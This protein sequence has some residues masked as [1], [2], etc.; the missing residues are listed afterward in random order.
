M[1]IDLASQLVAARTAGTQQAIS[2]A[3]LK[4]NH[5]MEMSLIQ[6]VADAAR[7]APPPGQGTRVDKLA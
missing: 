3:V 2:M 7:P 1:D 6:M 5:E 4:K